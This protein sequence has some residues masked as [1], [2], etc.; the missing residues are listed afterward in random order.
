MLLNYKVPTIA[1]LLLLTQLIYIHDFRFLC[2]S[3]AE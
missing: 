3:V 1:V 2:F